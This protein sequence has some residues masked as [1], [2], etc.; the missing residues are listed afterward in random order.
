MTVNLLG[1][2]LCLPAF[3]PLLAE[4]AQKHRTTSDINI[5]NIA[6]IGA[7][8]PG[9][10]AYGITKLDLLR[11]TEYVNS[12]HGKEGINAVSVHPGGVPTKTALG[13]P[14]VKDCE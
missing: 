1:P 7:H 9:A 3:V 8:S 11:L 6:S 2:Y 10:S 13:E 14:T 4:T 12:D 5:I